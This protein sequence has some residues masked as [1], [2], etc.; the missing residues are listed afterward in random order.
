MPAIQSFDWYTQQV[1]S[2]L[3][4]ETRKSLTEQRDYLLRIRNEDERRRFTEEVMK[5]VRSK[6][7]K[8]SPSAPKN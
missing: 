4:Q 1:W 7:R 2:S 8:A 3:D 6:I 5:E